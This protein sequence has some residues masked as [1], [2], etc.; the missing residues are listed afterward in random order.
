[1][2]AIFTDTV[3][4]IAYSI[5]EDTLNTTD[6]VSN[7][8][9]CLKDDIFGMTT[10]SIYTQFIPEGNSFTPGN[11]PQLDS[12]VLTLRYSGGFYGDTLKPFIVKV[13]ELDEAMLSTKTYYQNNSVAH[14]S[15]NLTYNPEFHLYP[16]PN[17]TVMVDTVKE[18]HIRIRLSDALGN[19]FLNSIDQM[20]T[21]ESFKT[22]FKGLYI[23]AEPYQNNGSMVNVTLTS[24][25]SGIQIYYKSEGSGVPKQFSLIVKSQE[26]VRF[27]A[28]Q[29]EYESGHSDFVRQVLQNDTAMGKD[30]LYLQSMGGVK[31]KITFPYIKEAFRG[32]N[33]AINKAELII[34]NIG[35]NLHLYPQPNRLN[36]HRIDRKGDPSLLPDFYTSIWGGAY[37]ADSA[38]Y[39]FRITRYMQDIISRD[40]HESFVYLVA[41][42]A[43][44]DA[45]RLVI[46]GTDTLAP[47]RLR[48][49]LYYTEY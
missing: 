18:A 49:K 20:Q 5:L 14:K 6:L 47:K 22:F 43:A 39:R 28:Y 45:N 7:Y 21:A 36:I 40:D 38:E 37:N 8:L 15:D 1:M 34:T 30:I 41:D 33:V 17:T 9:G 12:V 48:L 35:E 2:N 11:S 32:K 29:H 16:K 10:T 46:K 25:L 23:C 44:V 13:F 26:T 3:T 27:S 4:L 24:A 42:R 31:T 19:R